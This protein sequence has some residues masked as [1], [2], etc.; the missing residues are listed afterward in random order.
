MFRV[1]IK[2]AIHKFDSL[3]KAVEF[4]HKNGGSLYQKVWTTE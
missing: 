4:R 1:I 3:P 2:N